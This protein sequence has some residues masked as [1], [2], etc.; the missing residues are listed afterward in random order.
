MTNH[1]S[2]C[3]TFKCGRERERENDRERMRE[4]EKVNERMCG[5]YRRR[6]EEWKTLCFFKLARLS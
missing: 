2:K 1:L 5:K 3:V 4:R 6:E